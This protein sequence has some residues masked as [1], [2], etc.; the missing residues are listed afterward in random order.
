MSEF[1]SRTDGQLL[2][3]FTDNNDQVAFAALVERHGP[4]VHGICT[5][6]LGDRDEAQDATQAVFLALA[7]K[8]ASL[9]RDPSVGGWLHVVASRLAINLRRDRICRQ[10]HEEKAME[11][12]EDAAAVPVDARLFRSEV[13]VAIGAMPEKYRQPLVLFHLEEHSLEQTA[14]RL[15]LNVSTVGNRLARA[16]EML[17]AKLVRRGVEVGSVG[18]LTTLLSA[19]SGAAVLPATFVSATVKA[20]SLAAAGKLAAG[21]GTGVVSTNVAALTKGACN[22][23]FWSS[24]KTAAVITAAAIAAGGAGVTAY[25]AVAR[26]QASSASQSAASQP[27]RA[28]AQH[29][30]D[31]QATPAELTRGEKVLVSFNKWGAFIGPNPRE[32]DLARARKA[33]HEEIAAA[34]TKAGADIVRV[35]GESVSGVAGREYS[36][37]ML[38]DC[39]GQPPEKV[40]VDVPYRFAGVVFQD[41]GYLRGMPVESS[42]RFRPGIKTGQVPAAYGYKTWGAMEGRQCE[43]DLARFSTLE[44]VKV[45]FEGAPFGSGGGGGHVRLTPAPGHTLLEVFL[46]TEAGFLMVD[47]GPVATTPGKAPKSGRTGKGNFD[48]VRLEQAPVVVRARVKPYEKEAVGSVGPAMTRFSTLVVGE[49]IKDTSGQALAAGAE[50]G[51]AH[52]QRESL[53][54]GEFT[55]YLKTETI[56]LSSKENVRYNFTGTAAEGSRYPGA[57]QGTSHSVADK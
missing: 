38:L 39:R 25:V 1:D 13:D 11:E 44:G 20:A 5:R 8:A 41:G 28:G 55:A 4:M 10:R 31:R 22:M 54:A 56:E 53:P 3:A 24:V 34:V 12:R 2:A 52:D 48:P 32:E 9:K 16:R 46:L 18:A 19:E 51:L 7:R 15:G 21:V 50:I 33:V 43:A 36:A 23:L 37:M 45:E 40:L 29:S 26:E 57:G 47:P 30:L 27:K 49:V 42:S 17:R 35:C 14:R 6:I